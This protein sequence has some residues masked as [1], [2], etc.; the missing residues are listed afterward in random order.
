MTTH[1]PA[2]TALAAPAGHPVGATSPRPEA[3]IA[4]PLLLLLAGGAGLSVASLY[5]N[6]PLL[7]TMARDLGASSSAIGAVP[8][9]T[10]L[11]YAA[12][13]LLFGPLGDRLDRRRVVVAKLAALAVALL[14]AALAPSAGLL[15][16]AGLAIGLVATAAQDL[17]PAA[18]ALAPAAS[19]G[20]T[21]G[22]VMTGLL[23]GILLSRVVSGVVGAHVGW[24]AVYLGAAAAVAALSVAVGLRLPPMP[25]GS[26]ARYGA[27]LASIVR[28]ARDLAPLR[29]AALAQALLSVAF[30]AFW[31]T[32]TLALAAPPFRLGPVAAGAFGLAGAAGAAIAPLAGAAADRRGP[33]PVIRAGAALGVGS[34]AAIALF[35]GSLVVLVVATVVFDLGVQASLIAHQSVVY[36]LDPAARGRLN[37]VL[38]SAMF[39]G[40]AAGAAAASEVFAH[41]GWVGVAALGALAAATALAVRLAPTRRRDARDRRCIDAA[42][43]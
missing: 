35:P 15:A 2:P 5:Y 14:G 41:A 19:R 43:P 11:G 38:V 3:P 32:L 22:S 7:D 13:I 21:V 25:P 31:S 23:L 28:L 12:G 30:G 24:R 17:V 36:G 42:A 40:M 4:R 1:E 6:Q 9:L 26:R 33:E 18:A 27:L 39:L 37:A 20:R 8:T 16:V 29:R 34:F 10:Q